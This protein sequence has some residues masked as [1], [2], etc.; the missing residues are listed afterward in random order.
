MVIL[1]IA[2]AQ[3]FEPIRRSV[4]DSAVLDEVGHMTDCVSCGV[5]IADR[6][7]FGT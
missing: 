4:A 7:A 6:R 2:G 3:A 1:I 5:W